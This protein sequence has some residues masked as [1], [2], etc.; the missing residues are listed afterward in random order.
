MTSDFR[1]GKGVQKRPQILDVIHKGSTWVQKVFCNKSEPDISHST[2]ETPP[3]TQGVS[4][5]PQKYLK[6]NLMSYWAKI[7][8]KL[9]IMLNKIEGT[10]ILKLAMVKR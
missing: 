4:K 7:Q 10:P 9:E 3:E 1:V 5:N 6:I 8:Q 2:I